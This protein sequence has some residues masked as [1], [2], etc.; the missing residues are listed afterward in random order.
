VVDAGG[1]TQV[2]ADAGKHIIRTARASGVRHI[3][4]D[5]LISLHSGL[6]ENDASKMEDVLSVIRQVAHRG[7]VSVDLVHHIVKSHTGDTEGRAGDMHSGRGSA[8]ITG[9][10]RCAYTMARMSEKRGKA[11]FLSPNESARYVR[12][13]DAKA[14]YHAFEREAAWY[15]FES[16]N[17]TNGDSVGVLAPVNM[18]ELEERAEALRQ[19]GAIEEAGRLLRY[20]TTEVLA[21][22]EPLSVSAI[23]RQQPERLFEAVGLKKSAVEALIT[24]LFENDRTH[25]VTVDDREFRVRMDGGSGRGGRGRARML[26][27]EPVEN[28]PFSGDV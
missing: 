27:V 20:V 12:V 7:G 15:K 10:L 17:L 26:A 19:Q 25:P 22:G 4:L 14:N 21:A 28:T 3:V 5:P 23:T 24:T 8:A 18:A 6:S 2:N 9:A 1:Q 13:D 16:I 11:L